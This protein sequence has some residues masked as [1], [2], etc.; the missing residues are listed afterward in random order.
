MELPVIF[1][2]ADMVAID[3]PAG[4]LT[5]ATPGAHGESAEAWFRAHY[6]KV[7]LERA[8]AHRLDRETS[9]VLV[10]AKNQETYDY[11]RKAFTHREVKKEYLAAVYGVPKEKQ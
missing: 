2:N 8:Y 1:E 6:P 4:I 3:K 9:G 7:A 11:L 5:H 10:F